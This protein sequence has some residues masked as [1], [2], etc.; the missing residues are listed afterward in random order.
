[1]DTFTVQFTAQAP[2]ETLKAT[3]PA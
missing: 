3:V 2:L 1:M